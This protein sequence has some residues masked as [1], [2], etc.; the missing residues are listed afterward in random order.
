MTSLFT[1]S[2][3]NLSGDVTSLD[4]VANDLAVTRVS[5][6]FPLQG[7]GIFGRLRVNYGGRDWS[8]FVYNTHQLLKLKRNLTISLLNA[9]TIVVFV[10]FLPGKKVILETFLNGAFSYL[11]LPDYYSQFFFL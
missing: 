10:N 1:N 5:W 3:A 2:I 8:R 4:V 11:K 9:L 7:D 6:R